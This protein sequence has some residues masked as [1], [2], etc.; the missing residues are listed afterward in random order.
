LS[1]RIECCPM[2]IKR[3]ARALGQKG[4]IY[5]DPR[6]FFSISPA[7][8]AALGPDA[9]QRQP[10]VR[11]EMISAANARDVVERHCGLDDRSA[12]ERRRHAGEA[13]LRILETARRNGSAEFNA[14]ELDRLAA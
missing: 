2:T 12:A 13:R 8:L 14:Y 11:V 9:P 1:R 10:W 6:R 4:L 7:G 3:R 5:A